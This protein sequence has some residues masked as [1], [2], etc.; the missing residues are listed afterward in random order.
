EKEGVTGISDAQWRE[1]QRLVR[2]E[3]ARN[4]MTGA[5]QELGSAVNTYFTP[6]ERLTFAHFA[7]SKRAGMSAAD[8]EKFAIPL[9]ESAALAD[10]EARWRF[11]LMMQQAALPNFYGNVQ[12]LVELQRRR[13]AFA[14]LA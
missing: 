5:L 13:G 14:D 3:A 2:M 1:H 4:G 9:A 7:E 12:P 6:E 8:L 10:Q 11:D